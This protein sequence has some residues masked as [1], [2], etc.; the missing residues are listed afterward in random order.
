MEQEAYRH[1]PYDIEV[2]QAL[3]GAILVDNQ[4]LERVSAVLRAEHFYDP[5]HQRLYE[6]MSGSMERGGMV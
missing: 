5:L 4:A 1:V 3:L 2:E 6:A